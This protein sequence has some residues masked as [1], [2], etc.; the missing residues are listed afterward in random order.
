MHI[1]GNKKGL[2]I[3]CIQI[4][5]TKWF[6][7][8]FVIIIIILSTVHAITPGGISVIIACTYYVSVSLSLSKLCACKWISLPPHAHLRRQLVALRRHWLQP[9]THVA[10]LVLGKR[11]RKTTKRRGKASGNRSIPLLPGKWKTGV[12]LWTP[13][14]CP[15]CCGILSARP[16]G[17][18]Q[19]RTKHRISIRKIRE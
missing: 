15:S 9:A 5:I 10:W 7:S 6:R 16:R 18:K 12:S 1:Y 2:H 14:S 8:V 19:R 3:L 4:A 17:S 13:E 11:K